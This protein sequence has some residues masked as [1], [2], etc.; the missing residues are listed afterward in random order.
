VHTFTPLLGAQIDL[1]PGAAVELPVDTAFEHGV[2]LDQGSVDVGGTTLGV[3]DLWY[4]SPGHDVV[5]L[6]NAAERSARIVL[7]GGIPF[8][9][10]LVMW[11]N[12][13]GRSH[14]DIVGYRRQWEGHDDRFGSVADYPG[15]RLS[16][17][18]LPNSTLLP[19]PNP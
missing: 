9:E 6:A 17:P 5:A 4:Q 14:D 12:F 8:T 10:E 3:A 18:P 19:R 7:L 2:L 16:A 15:R 13:V 11:W 1:A